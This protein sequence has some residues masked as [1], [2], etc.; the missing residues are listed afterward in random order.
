MR[1]DSYHEHQSIFFKIGAA[2]SQA[3]ASCVQLFNGDALLD[4]FPPGALPSV[5]A[6]M[7]TTPQGLGLQVSGMAGEGWD[8]AVKEMLQSFERAFQDGVEL[9]SLTAA[10]VETQDR[11]VA[12]YDLSKAARRTLDIS[13]LLQLLTDE[14]NRLLSATGAF[15]VL[16]QPGLPNLVYQNCSPPLS[17][18]QMLEAARQYRSFPIHNNSNDFRSMPIGSRNALMINIPVHEGVIGI[19]AVFNRAGVFSTPDIKLAIALAEQT[20]AQLENAMLAQETLVRARFETEINLAHQVQT[21]LLPQKLPPVTGLDLYAV[22][23]PA[24]EVGGD[25]FDLVLLPE[26]PFTFLLG[27]VTGK[28]MPSAM[29]MTMTRTVGRSAARNMPYSEPHQLMQRLNTDLLDDYSTV[30]MFCTVFIGVFDD[31]RRNLKYCNAGQSPI[32]HLPAE[33]EPVLLPAGD[34]PIGIFDGH[35]YTSQEISLGSGDVLVI[36]SDGLPEARNNNEEMFG[37]ERMKMTLSAS[38]HLSAKAMVDTLFSAV[39]SFSG[40]QYKED[41]CTIIIIKV[42]SMPKK[43]VSIQATFEEVRTIDEALRALLQEEKIPEDI[44]T[45]CELAFHELLTNRV[46]HAYNGDPNGRIIVTMSVDSGGIVL[47][48]RDTGTPAD[49][50][51]KKVKMPD[52]TELAES[53]YG[54]AI[55]MAI[56]DEVD[57]YTVNGENIWRISKKLKPA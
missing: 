28:G 33:G 11:L 36:A 46:D 2:L 45:T 25:F 5:P 26:H 34:I 31:S 23:V 47:E 40:N 16:T 15:S 13:T 9:D 54:L 20:G 6:I 50:D 17:E 38:R 8:F 19:L 39:E 10:L 27:D 35:E 4:T 3:G 42:N 53:G 22:S 24:R 56:M 12:M 18:E 29:L 44:I 30:G 55:M 49:L 43:I 32:I 1:I 52:P 37:Y 51:L 7:V 14:I 48:T 21:A 41:D 57:F